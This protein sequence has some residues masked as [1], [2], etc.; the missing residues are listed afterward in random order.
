MPRAER[1]VG[2]QQQCF[3]L[4]MHAHGYGQ[5]LPPQT[6]ID[7]W[8]VDRATAYRWKANYL[9]A[10]DWARKHAGLGVHSPQ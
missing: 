5:S 3:A 6:I 8:A 4:W 2:Q 7:Y 1:N 10:R 9:A